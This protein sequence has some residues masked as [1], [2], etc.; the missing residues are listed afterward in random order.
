MPAGSDLLFCAHHWRD[1]SDALRLVAVVIH[2]E[3]DR[4]ADV[5]ATATPD[6]R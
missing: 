3:L 5:P 6:E 1:N 2:Q 4:L